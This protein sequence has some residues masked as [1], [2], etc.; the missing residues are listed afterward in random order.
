MVGT[1][2]ITI[3]LHGGT[4]KKFLSEIPEWIQEALQQKISLQ[5]PSSKINEA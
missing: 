5:I 4:T 3:G 1:L 2:Q